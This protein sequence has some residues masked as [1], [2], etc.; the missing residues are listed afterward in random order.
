MFFDS[1]GW[2]LMMNKLPIGI[3]IIDM[4]TYNPLFFNQLISDLTGY[5]LDNFNK[6]DILHL[7]S[8]DDRKDL[9]DL[10]TNKDSAN[11]NLKINTIKGGIIY[12]MASSFNFENN[13]NNYTVLSFIDITSSIIQSE[14]LEKTNIILKNFAHIT[15][16]DLK[17]PLIS[18]NTLSEKIIIEMKN[19]NDII[20]KVK[21]ENNMEL[22]EYL[23]LTIETI[24]KKIR[25][26]S[27]MVGDST[28]E[29]RK[30]IERSLHYS[31]TDNI[32]FSIF[33]LN[34]AINSAKR[35]LKTKR[36]LYS[37]KVTYDIP[38]LPEINADLEKIVLVFQ[39]L[40]SNAMKFNDKEEVIIK[41]EVEDI[42][43]FWLISVIDNGMGIK[44]KDISKIFMLYK[45]FHGSKIE[46]SGLG[47]S[48]VERIIKSHGGEIKVTSKLHK[49]T[50][51]TFTIPK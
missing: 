14:L 49:K 20:S 47:L 19:L 4:K 21:L 37:K 17:S 28:E 8:E 13:S 3:C 30:T 39:N 42:D 43:G 5:S 23:W 25:K 41:V 31:E 32:E 18:L 50:K 38:N 16:H 2:E 40:F 7:V 29:M 22:T 34:I 35:N 36:S 51:F 9:V 27:L 33:N 26:L 1:K 11:Y 6:K 24:K 10:I 12:C 46:G 48:I 15:A 45:R 44:K